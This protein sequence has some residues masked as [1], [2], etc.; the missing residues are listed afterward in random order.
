MV[1]NLAVFFGMIIYFNMIPRNDKLST[2]N[3]LYFGPR[4]RIKN[5]LGGDFYDLAYRIFI[6]N[7][8]NMIFYSTSYLIPKLNLTT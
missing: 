4:L 6:M 2:G 1:Q 5:S 8:E 7:D 3:N